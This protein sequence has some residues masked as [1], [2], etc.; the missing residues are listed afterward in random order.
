MVRTSISIPHTLLYNIKELLNAT[1]YTHDCL[2]CS[3]TFHTQKTTFKTIIPSV[4][5]TQSWLL[6]RSRQILLS[7]IST[8]WVWPDVETWDSSCHLDHWVLPHLGGVWGRS[9]GHSAG[10]VCGVCKRG[11]LNIIDVAVR[12]F[13]QLLHEL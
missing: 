11:S 12:V 2:V 5:W 7:L 3:L 9:L 4:L 10:I 13:I 6:P 1:L 8:W